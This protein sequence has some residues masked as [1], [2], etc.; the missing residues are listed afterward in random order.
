MKKL[1]FILGLGLMFGSAPVNKM[2]AQVYVNFNIDIQPAWGPSGYEYAEFYYIPEVNIYYDVVQRLYYYPSGNRW[3]CSSYLP[4][5]YS[6]YDFYSL[7]K[8][9]LNGILQPWRYN[10]NHL[11]LYAHYRYNYLQMPIFYMTDYRYMRARVNYFHWVEP[12][13]MPR[14]EGRPLTR[15]FAANNPNGRI[16]NDVRPT[17]SSSRNQAAPYQSVR[18]NSGSN[19]NRSANRGQDF[20]SDVQRG[21]TPPGYRS[22]N[23]SNSNSA[24]RNSSTTVQPN[25]NNSTPRNNPATVQPNGNNSTPRNSSTTVQPNGNNSA[26]RNNPA[27]VQPNSNNN[28][29]PRNSSTTVQPSSNNS[30]PRNNPATVQPNSN[31]SA[32]RN[33]ST[34]VQPNSNS[35]SNRSSVAPVRSGSSNSSSG[36][37]SNSS[38]SGSSQSGGSSTRR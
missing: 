25:S 23:Q 28:S 1:I 12:H 18:S 8:V 11:R 19:Y 36:S 5:S 30:A 20:P 38:G 22:S 17:T 37:S 26:P 34:T 16:S 31:N 10:A 3:I 29:T 14:N 6:Y 35:N 32:P 2:E 13:Y 7:Y 27:T 15:N 4:V 9:V 21:S 33:S 24:P